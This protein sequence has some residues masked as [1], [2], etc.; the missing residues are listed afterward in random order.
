MPGL[1]DFLSRIQT[2]YSFYLEFRQSPQETLAPY[3]LSS[4]ERAALIE[5]RPELWDHLERTVFTL[6]TSHNIVAL[7]SE[8]L[9]V[10]TDAVLSQSK[11]GQ[12]IAQIRNASTHSDRLT[13][14]SALIEHI[15][16]PSIADRSV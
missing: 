12:T 11:I 5:S 14:V 9:E 6:T 16:R 8:N 10:N 7:G 4:E 15:G 13:A 2:D 1:N 3:E